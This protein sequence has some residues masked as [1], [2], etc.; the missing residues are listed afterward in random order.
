MGVDE[1]NSRRA[2]GPA[3]VMDPVTLSVSHLLSTTYFFKKQCVSCVIIFL[4]GLFLALISVWYLG[5]AAARPVYR[6]GDRN[7]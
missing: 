4:L 6:C 5:F 1:K 3:S 7:L 2:D